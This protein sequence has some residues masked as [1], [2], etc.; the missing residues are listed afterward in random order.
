MR[1]YSCFIFKGSKNHLRLSHN[2]YFWQV[3]DDLVDKQ[4]QVT[5]G[6]FPVLRSQEQFTDGLLKGG[7]GVVRGEM[8]SVFNSA[9]VARRAFS[10]ASIC[11]VSIAAIRF[12]S[13]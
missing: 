10:T 9:S 12:C 8:E 5:L 3:N 6:H 1:S 13:G 2:L 4:L 11:S 7:N